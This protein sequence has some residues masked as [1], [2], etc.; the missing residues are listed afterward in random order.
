MIADFPAS[1][2]SAAKWII[3]QP[4]Q[5]SG[6]I[7][8]YLTVEQITRNWNRCCLNKALDVLKFYK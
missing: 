3:F 7:P 4:K 6:F 5:K 2:F 8:D 1:H